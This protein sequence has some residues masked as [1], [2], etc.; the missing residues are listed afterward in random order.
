MTTFEDL[1]NRASDQ[2]LQD[3][4]GHDV[5]RL[6]VGLDPALARPER[7]SEIALGLRTPADMLLD[8][9][10]RSELLLLLPRHS[11]EALATRLS[12]TGDPFHGLTTMKV[13]RGSARATDLLDFFAV[14]DDSEQVVTLPANETITPAHPLFAHQRLA[15]AR[16]LDNLEREPHRV[17]LHMPTGSGKTRTAMSVVCDLLNQREPRLVVWLAHSEELC[18]QAV[19]EFKKA[20]AHLGNRPVGVQR[21]W[22]SHGLAEPIIRDGIIVAGLSKA[23]SSVRKSLAEI[24]TIAGHVGLVVMDEA[25]QAV[26]PTYSQLLDV[27]TESGR[28]APL[29]GLTA[30]PGRTWNDIDED[31]RLADFFYRRKVSL[32]VA[33]YDNPIEYLVDEGYLADTEFEQLRYTSE[34]EL[35]IREIEE[36]EE[37]LD[38]PQRIINA[39]A[40]DEQRNMLI[41]SRTEAMCRRHNRLIVF[42]AT[43]SHAIVLATV[44]RARGYWAYAVT[45]ETPANDRGRIIAAFK[46]SSDEPRIIVNFGVLT[47]GFDAPQ[48]SAAV[49]ARPTKSLVLFSQMVGRATR[50]P[51]AGGNKQAEVATVVDTRL[52]GFCNMADAFDNWEDVW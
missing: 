28:P 23:Y 36:L 12:V 27:L 43:K 29:L 16:V 40:A 31:E 15:A 19:E 50:G 6:L 10:L 30:T 3:L 44:L 24:G 39:L 34:G 52:P 37:A 42:A 32:E 22:G 21:W 4:V 9:A 2:L 49:I 11:A 13:R 14:A 26:A 7:L 38:I 25:H 48:T 35:S 41:L 8:S 1:L 47:T 17:M 45:G 46:T 20:W 51:K 18:E 33:G 5:V